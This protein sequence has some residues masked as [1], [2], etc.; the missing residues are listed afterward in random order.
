MRS[1]SRRI[2]STSASALSKRRSPRRRARNSRRSCAAVEIA[3]EVQQVGLDQLAA[4]GLERRA[5][6]D[7]DGGRRSARPS[8]QARVDA[9]AGAHERL[10][11]DQVGGR[12]AQLAP[13]LV[14]VHDLAAQL[15]RRA[16]QA[17]GLIDLAGEHAARGCGWRRRSRR[18][19]PAA[20]ARRVAKR[21]SAASSARIALRAVAEAEVLADRHLLRAERADE[22]LVDE[23]LR[24]CAA[25]N[26]ASKGIT[27]SSSTPSAATSSALRSSVV[28]SFG[29]CCGRDHRDRVRVEREH[30]VRARDHLAVA[31]V[32][33]VEGADGH[34]ARPLAALDVGQA[35][36]LHGAEAYC[37]RPRDAALS[38]ST[39]SARRAASAPSGSPRARAA[40]TASRDL[41]RPDRGAPQ[42]Q[43]VG[44]AEVGDQRAHVGARA[45]FDLEA[46]RSRRRSP[47]L[48][49]EL[50]RS[51]AR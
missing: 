15:E 45:A 36:D 39:R 33:A 29:V 44:V 2:C 18:R 20:G 35:G 49:P 46:A 8:A 11:G 30:A 10:V 5:H 25:A 51:G 21:S 38:S 19:P 22:H 48:A 34:A 31:E 43:A 14:A 28:S 24:R 37:A 27:I 4:A 16:E 12:E 6:A 40:A 50:A 41:E 1:T 17:V 9:V 23:L 3:V 47:P 7:A 26:S 13:A 42:L 32:H